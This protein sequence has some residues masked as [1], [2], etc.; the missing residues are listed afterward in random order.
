MHPPEVLAPGLFNLNVAAIYARAAPGMVV[1]PNLRL[2][3]AV[4]YRGK[5]DVVI[6]LVGARGGYARAL[7]PNMAIHSYF[8]AQSPQTL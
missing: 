7:L 8:V 5:L 2:N 6:W 4:R 1:S 3:L